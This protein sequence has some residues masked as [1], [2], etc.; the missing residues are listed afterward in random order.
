MAETAA[1]K[2]IGLRGIKVADTRISDVDGEKGVIIYRGYN[3][4]DLA[5]S[6]SYEEVIFLLLEDHLPTRHEL[7]RFKLELSS[8]REIPGVVLEFMQ[9]MPTSAHPMDILQ[10]SIPMLACYDPQLHEET[11]EANA[12][13]AVRLT[14]RIP[15]IIAGWDRIRKGLEPIHP[16]SELSHAETSCIC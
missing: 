12:K 16:R 8:E 1:T 7:E 11:R 3:V 4:A 15:M 9:M 10:A 6:S 13:K 5:K 14:A 2:N